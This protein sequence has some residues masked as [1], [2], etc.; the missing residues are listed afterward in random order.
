MLVMARTRA[1]ADPTA[2]SAT[3]GRDL[4]HFFD[5]KTLLLGAV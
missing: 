2:R 5:F 1:P 3:V 4:N